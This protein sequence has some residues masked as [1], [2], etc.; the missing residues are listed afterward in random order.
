MIRDKN[1]SLSE[2]EY[3]YLLIHSPKL[4]PVSIYRLYEEFGSFE[5]VFKASEERLCAAGF[6]NEKQ[7]GDI[8]RLGKDSETDAILGEFYELEKRGV[9]FITFLDED[10]P[11]RLK[12]YRD[13]PP[14]LFVK[15]ELPP[16][17][18]PS[19]AIVGARD[20]TEYGKR[21]AEVY[22]RVLSEE[23]ISVISGL[24]QGVDCEAHRSALAAGMKTYGVLGCGIYTC[25]PRENYDI[26][27]RMTRNGGVITEFVPETPPVSVNFPRRNRI[28]SGLSD[29]VIVIEAREKSGSLITADLALEQGKDVMALPGRIS[30]PFSAGCNE[31]IRNGA[32]I[33][34]SPADVIDHLGLKRMKKLTLHKISE[35]R[36]ANQEKLL[37]SCLD[38]RPGHI[39]KIMEKSGLSLTECLE[40]LLKLELMGF[41]RDCGNQFY[42]RKQ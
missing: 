25:Y 8:L 1:V 37:Y 42:C 6:M 30:D 13:S 21:A 23:G 28:I 14:A 31:L 18:I 3:L 12:P 36:L 4:G 16:D 20:C 11:E 38:F 24:A 34:L 7:I 35:K 15:G 19:V 41:V 32:M 40:S 22:A 39:E 9:K 26:Y 27:E 17:D 5:E 10:Y 29:I 33:T 2:S